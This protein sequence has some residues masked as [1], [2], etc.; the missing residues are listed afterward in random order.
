MLQLR[1]GMYR[2]QITIKRKKYFLGEYPTLEEAA[3]ARKRG[4]EIYHKPYLEDEKN[5]P[6]T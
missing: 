6:G 1:T 2:A 5:P 4:E 3:A